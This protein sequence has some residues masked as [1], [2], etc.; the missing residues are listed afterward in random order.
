MAKKSPAATEGATPDTEAEDLLGG[1]PKDDL[2]AADAKPSK[3]K[4]AATSKAKGTAKAANGAAKPAAKATAAKGAKAANGAAKP[5]AKASKAAANGAANGATKPAKAA[6]PK[7]AKSGEARS[8]RGSGKFFPD[9]AVMDPLR[10]QIAS[11]KKPLTT[12]EI[13]EKFQVLTWQARL[14]A[15]GL[16]KE[17]KGNLAKVGSVLV[18]TPGG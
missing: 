3:P 11:L 18:Y 6:K 5:T 12:K 1:E 10:K 4:K 14:G 16:A 8:I 9:P 17:G 7:A 13:A 15:V 2:L